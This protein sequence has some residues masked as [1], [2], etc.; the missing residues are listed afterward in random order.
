[1]VF[2][3]SYSVKSV[4]FPHSSFQQLVGRYLEGETGEFP[5]FCLPIRCF[6]NF[7]AGKHLTLSLFE[8]RIPDCIFRQSPQWLT[9][10][11]LRRDTYTYAQHRFRLI[12]DFYVFFYWA[13]H[14]VSFF[15]F[16]RV[17]YLTK[18][19]RKQGMYEKGKIKRKTLLEKITLIDFDLINPYC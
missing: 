4:W 1:M 7:N 3:A 16:P 11:G 17:C 9:W 13:L 5:R 12:N 18:Y 8:F 2:T 19:C 6:G 10:N 14:F 15:Y